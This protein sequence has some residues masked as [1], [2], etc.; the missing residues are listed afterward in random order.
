MTE[1]YPIGSK[2]IH[3]DHGRG[4]IM[5]DPYGDCKSSEVLFHAF[6]GF[7]NMPFDK[8]IVRKVDLTRELE[9][10]EK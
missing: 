7:L 5:S 2:W 10:N 3:K 9:D 6:N 4:K 1:T 8:D